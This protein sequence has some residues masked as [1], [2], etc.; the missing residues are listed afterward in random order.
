MPDLPLN[1]ELT[2][3]VYGQGKDGQIVKW[4]IC[5]FWS[6]SKTSDEFD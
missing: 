5:D 6:M 1:L 2:K 3:L 4:L